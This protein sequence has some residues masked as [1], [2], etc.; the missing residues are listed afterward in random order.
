MYFALMFVSGT[1]LEL[2][3]RDSLVNKKFHPVV[4][5]C[6]V[7]AAKYVHFFHWVHVQK[8]KYALRNRLDTNPG[9]STLLLLPTSHLGDF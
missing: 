1:F 4:E 6:H 7:L 9:A 3:V 2:S 8:H 5:R